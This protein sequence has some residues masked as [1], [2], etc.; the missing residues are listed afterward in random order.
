M[1]SKESGSGLVE[2]PDLNG[3]RGLSRAF[4]WLLLPVAL[5]GVL[6]AAMHIADRFGESTEAG[7]GALLTTLAIFGG[8][9]VAAGVIGLVLELVA[10]SRAR[11]ASGT[12]GLVPMQLTVNSYQQAFDIVGDVVFLPAKD[13]GVLLALR[14]DRIEIYAGLNEYSDPRMVLPCGEIT[15][16]EQRR[17]RIYAGDVP[18]IA[19]KHA[20]RIFELGFVRTVVFR[21]IEISQRL[22]ERRFREIEAAVRGHSEGPLR[23]S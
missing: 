11:S 22:A 12:W 4:L 6:R 8:I 7:T 17:V 19:F 5:A 2:A 20:G 18:G 1:S 14:G 13:Q 21:P 9:G 3:Q 10:H 16:I 15:G 23:G